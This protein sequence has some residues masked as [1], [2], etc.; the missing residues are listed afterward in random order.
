MGLM[1][2]WKS[3]GALVAAG[4][5]VAVA[6]GLLASGQATG[7]RADR[8]PFST[9]ALT[10][11]LPAPE[12]WTIRAENLEI[13]D[14]TLY[15]AINPRGV[16]TAYFFQYGLTPSYGR[17]AGY[18]N[19]RYDGNRRY[20]VESVAFDLRPGATYHY[21]IVAK[22]RAGTTF[23]ADKTFTSLHEWRPKPDT[24]IACFHERISRFTAEAHPSRCD[25]WGYRGRQFVGIPIKGMKWGH[26]GA[27]P[28]RAAYGVALR[29]GTRVRVIAFR[30]VRCDEGT[31]WYSRAVVVTLDD[32]NA[33]EL[34]LLT[35]DGPSVIGK[36]QVQSVAGSL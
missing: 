32:G 16:P 25:L 30:P 34:R 27:N 17:T 4:A 1:N 28:T 26:W 7:S 23:G 21:R 12:A 36:P 11:K 2:M 24:L 18:A 3:A 13:G 19:H 5:V 20:A 9:T 10:G 33:F 14:A 31:A 35:C 15:G 8:S 29:D 6:T 22:S